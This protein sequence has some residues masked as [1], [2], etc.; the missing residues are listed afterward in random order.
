MEN[1]LK[2]FKEH[3]G[4]L[5]LALLLVIGGVKL[6]PTVQDRFLSPCKGVYQEVRVAEADLAEAIDYRNSAVTKFFQLE[7]SSSESWGNDDIGE[8]YTKMLESDEP[9]YEK[10]DIVY[11]LISMEPN[12]FSRTEVIT[13]AKEIKSYEDYLEREATN[14]GRPIYLPGFLKESDFPQWRFTS[15][16]PEGK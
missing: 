9:V 6:Y 13:S 11:R 2:Y 10:R 4:Y 16:I 1:L 3:D 5:W 14:T 8:A 15:V 7:N 12:C